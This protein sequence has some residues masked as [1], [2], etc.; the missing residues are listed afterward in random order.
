MTHAS[1]IL[2]IIIYRRL[3]QTIESSLDKDQFG[4]RKERGTR[5]ALLSLQLIQ[6]GRLQVGKR[7]FIAFIDLKK[8][9][10]NVSWLKFCNKLEN[11]GIKYK[12]MRIIS[13]IYRNQ[14]VVVEMQWERGKASIRKG[15]RQG[16][17]FSPPLFSLY[18]QGAIIEIKE[19]IKNISI[20]V[21]GKTIKMLH[22]VDDIVLP[23][24]SE[25]ELK[26]VLNVTETVFNN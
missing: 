24:N 8:A 22:F 7:T 4:F 17:S 15:I 3:E 19:E 23:A 13:S 10:D 9:Y 21:Q 2:I 18:S 14:K 25:R 16:C 1:K 11:N 5:E 6:S 26:E 12:D 20:K